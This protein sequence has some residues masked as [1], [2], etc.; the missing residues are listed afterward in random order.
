MFRNKREGSSRVQVISSEKWEEGHLKES[1][2]GKC[3]RREN[4]E[5]H[6]TSGLT[7]EKGDSLGR[8]KGRKYRK[9]WMK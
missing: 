9:R 8:G 1:E 2:G 6:N 3:R 5:H 4:W 7:G